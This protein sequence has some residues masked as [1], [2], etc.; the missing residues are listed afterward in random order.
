MSQTTEQ[1]EYKVNAAITKVMAEIETADTK[2]IVSA[3]DQKL[4]LAMLAN[5]R[6]SHHRLD[7]ARMLLALRTRIVNEGH[8]WWTWHQEHFARSK[9]DAQR[10]LAIASAENVELAA[11]EAAEKN[12]QHQAAHRKKVAATYVSRGLGEVA[13]MATRQ[14]GTPTVVSDPKK[15]VGVF[16]HELMNLLDDYCARLETFLEANPDLDEDCLGGLINVLE[17]N[18]M[19]LQHL[20]QQVDGR[21]GGSDQATEHDETRREAEAQADPPLSLTAQQRLA[22][23]I[24]KHQRKLDAEFEGRVLADIK[25]RVEEL[26][27]PSYRESEEDAARVIKA[28]KGVFKPGEYNAILRCVHPDVQPSIEQKTEAFRLVHENRL[29]LLSA[30]NDAKPKVYRKMPTVEE[31]MAGFDGWN[32]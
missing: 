5:N 16:F 2:R 18:S 17:L 9:R 21:D 23:A 26:V 8:D 19:R 10:L 14:V 1:Y 24:R 13:E 28:R 15:I 27:L 25:R 29:V 7:A 4:T 3:I 20:A 22:G 32:K 12:A 6:A 31:F 30:K 11:E